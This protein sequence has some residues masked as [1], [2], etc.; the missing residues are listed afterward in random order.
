M[1]HRAS[2]E[3]TAID[4]EMLRTRARHACAVAEEVIAESDHALWFSL[5][6]R[7]YSAWL[8]AELREVCFV[9]ARPAEKPSP[10]AA[11]DDPRAKELAWVSPHGS[12]PT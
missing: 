5:R 3:Q 11:V 12:V 8:R 7:Q 1:T 6:H 10:L 4:H 2:S 9:T